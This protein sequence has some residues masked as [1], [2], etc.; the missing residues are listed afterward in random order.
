[1]WTMPAGYHIVEAQRPEL[2][3]RVMRIEE[4]M[5]VFLSCP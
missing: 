2:P 5:E 4:D 3:H 1:M